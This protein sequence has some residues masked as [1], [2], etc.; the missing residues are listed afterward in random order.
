MFR[1]LHPHRVRLRSA[2]SLLSSER[3]ASGTPELRDPN[4]GTDI[5]M[6]S[7][8]HLLKLELV[9]AQWLWLKMREVAQGL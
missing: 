7:C 8:L 2:V 3:A 5:G 6:L 9:N 4:I 1:L